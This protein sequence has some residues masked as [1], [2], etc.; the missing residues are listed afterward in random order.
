MLTFAGEP[1]AVRTAALALFDVALATIDL[2]RHQGEHPRVGTVDV[3]IPQLRQGSI[4]G[5]VAGAPRERAERVLT[6]VVATCYLLG[7][8]TRRMDR[9]VASQGITSLSKSQ[10]SE[11]VRIAAPSV[12]SCSC[13]EFY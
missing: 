2:R 13:C 12:G 4:S 1:V 10:V 5:M 9:L 8:S 11:M 3:A 7:V 6:S